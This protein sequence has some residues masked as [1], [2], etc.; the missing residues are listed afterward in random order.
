MKKEIGMKAS[1]EKQEFWKGH[2]ENWKSSGISQRKYCEENGIN[3]N[4]FNYWCK[5]IKK[6]RKESSFI[7][8]DITQDF[9]STFEITIKS[10]YTIKLNNNYCSESLQ[11]L[12]RTLESV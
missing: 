8:L 11:N 12:I 9:V 5:K 2:L 6:N 4:T 1:N 7:R 3:K 10:K